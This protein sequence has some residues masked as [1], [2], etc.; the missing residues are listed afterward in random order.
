MGYG[1][2][3]KAR[4]ASESVKRYSKSEHVHRNYMDLAEI[5]EC[6]CTEEEIIDDIATLRAKSGI[7]NNFDK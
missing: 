5:N 3:N 6:D 2:P 4:E 7:P 1:E